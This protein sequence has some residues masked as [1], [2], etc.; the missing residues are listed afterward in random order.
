MI[1]ES[2]VLIFSTTFFKLLQ[3]TSNRCTIILPYYVVPD[4][5]NDFS[6]SRFISGYN[7][8]QISPTKKCK[9]MSFCQPVCIL[10]VR[11]YGRMPDDTCINMLCF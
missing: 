8:W 2:L 5:L 9:S 3:F 4:A 7:Y 6:R 1:N 10:S 11:K